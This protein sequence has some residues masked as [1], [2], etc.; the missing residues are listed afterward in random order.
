MTA[1]PA[2]LVSQAAAQLGRRLVLQNVELE[3]WPGEVVSLFGHNGAGKS[4]LLRCIMG[5]VPLYAG[6]IELGFTSWKRD[7]HALMRKGVVYLPQ[8]HKL[9]SSLTVRDNLL[10]YAEAK[11][12]ALSDFEASYQQ[13]AKYFPVL[14]RAAKTTSG[15]LSGGEIQQ[16][17]IAR[18]LLPD[19][20]LL[21]LDEPTLGLAARL[22]TEVFHILQDFAA[23]SGRSVLIAE[24]R[25]QEALV[26]SRRAYI[27]RQGRVVMSGEAPKLLEKLSDLEAA[28]I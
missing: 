16:V 24:H 9:F 4:T 3:V 17:A 7:P 10:V 14:N 26:F 15:K 28:I 22:R 13:L 5:V 21:L 11:G 20:Q 12:L 8:N 27:L 23:N 18:A 19:S 1:K 2:L 6:T 25:I